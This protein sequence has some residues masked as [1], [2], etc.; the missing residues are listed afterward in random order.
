MYLY[1]GNYVSMATFNL[2]E[3]KKPVKRNILSWVGSR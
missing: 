3:N 1:I 2:E